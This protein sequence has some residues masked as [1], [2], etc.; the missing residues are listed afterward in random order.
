MI[1]QLSSLFP[2]ILLAAVLAF[3][4]S[5]L[6]I[7]LSKHLGLIDRPGSAP[8]KQ[9]D[10]PTPLAGGIV[11][12]LSIPLVFFSIGPK[13]D[14]PSIVILAGA[15]GMGLLGLLDDR[16]L[17]KP[18]PKLLAQ[19]AL[20]TLILAFGVKVQVTRIQWV[21]MI[22]TYLWVIGLTNAFNFVDSMDGLALG[23]GGIA[24][25][26]FMLVTIESNQP[27]LASM[28]AILVGASVG[29]FFFAAAPAKLFL[30]DSGALALGFFLASIGISYTPGEAGLPQALTWFIPILVLGVPIFDMTL[31]IIHRARSGHPIFKG[32]MDHTYHR[33][34]SM[35][36]DVSR[37]VLAM[38][39]AAILLGLIA[40][41]TLDA[42][43]W[44]ANLAFSL[45][46]F[47]GIGV[48]VYFEWKVPP[49]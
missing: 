24:A 2:F 47:L 4:L 41:I 3:I 18:L 30:G 14:V 49:G 17:L 43:V 5:P 39:I 32:G 35:G 45:I 29:C 9:H 21:D 15:A 37:A 12:I 44:A 36:L 27:L 25:A 31:V 11:L 7:L 6:S 23:L 48:V 13:P 10:H 19:F 33:L 34:K 28:S 40:F 20:V 1:L 8:H 26:F 22:L 16:Y 38:Q 42:S 46:V